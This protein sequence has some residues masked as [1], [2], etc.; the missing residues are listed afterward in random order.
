MF[1]VP[2]NVTRIVATELESDRDNPEP[3]LVGRGRPPVEIFGN[4]ST[5]RPRRGCLR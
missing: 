4:G 3:R 5:R 1:A 2:S